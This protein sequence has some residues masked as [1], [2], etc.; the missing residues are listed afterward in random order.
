M[1][2][3]RDLSEFRARRSRASAPPERCPEFAVHGWLRDGE[4]EWVHT[5]FVGAPDNTTRMHALIDC[6]WLV[7]RD[8]DQPDRPQPAFWWVLDNEG[9]HTFLTSPDLFS[10]ADWRRA[11]DFARCWWRLTRKCARIAWRMARGK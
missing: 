9:R 11:A 4:V 8:F 6:A 2:V 7:G 1:T 5:N 3:V 10:G